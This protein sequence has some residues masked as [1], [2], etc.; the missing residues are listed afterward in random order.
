MKTIH[1]KI[2]FLFILCVLFVVA[3]AFLSYQNTLYLERKLL[4]VE[5]FDDLLNEVLELR[6]YEKN[7]IF[8]RDAVS[9]EQCS[10]YLVEVES[11]FHQI[12]PYII[13]AAGREKYE[14]FKGY[15]RDYNKLLSNYITIT[16]NGGK[17]VNLAQIRENGK[18]IVTFSEELIKIKRAHIKVR[19]HRNVIYFV[20]LL[21]F[22]FLLF[23]GIFQMIGSSILAP[24]RAVKK[25]TGK[26]ASDE[27]EPIPNPANRDDEVSQLIV[28]FNKMAAEL[29]KRENQ[30]LQSRKMAAIGTFTSGIA[31]ELNNPINNI[32]LIVESLMEDDEQLSF[33]ERQGLYQNLMDQ[34]D[35]TSDIVQNLLEFSRNRYAKV[36]KVALETIVQ[37]TANLIK[38]EMKLNHI[39]FEQKVIDGPLPQLKVDKSGLQ[40]V[41]L[42]LFLNS[43]HAMN[44][45]G[46]IEVLMRVE[47]PT[48]EVR[49][50]VRDTG[51]GIPA[52]HLERLFDPFFS[53]KKEGEGTGLG[54]SVSYNIIDKHG[55]RIEVESVLEQGACFSIFLPIVNDYEPDRR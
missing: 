29:Q 41:F 28:A 4:I 16:R 10:Y 23:V 7:L 47:H 18:K 1:S 52:E 54:L 31:H 49:I 46:R 19:L 48:N 43:I 39:Q 53:T 13:T 30:L 12:A 15:L 24:L 2:I 26:V 44:G 27:F 21:S 35:R 22:F 40:Q 37:K 8:Y 55:G 38:N 33:Q 32:S 17:L 25:A 20:V 3:L 5:S 36:D 42:N 9:L 51:G 11:S 50:D 14:Q 45:G 34:A 6:R